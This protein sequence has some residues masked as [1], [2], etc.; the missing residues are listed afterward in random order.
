MVGSSC[1]ES[2][3]FLLNVQFCTDR[4]FVNGQ[5]WRY[6]KITMWGTVPASTRGIERRGELREQCLTPRRGRKGVSMAAPNQFPPREKVSSLPNLPAGRRHSRSEGGRCRQQKTAPLSQIPAQIKKTDLGIPGCA[7]NTT[8]RPPSVILL[9]NEGEPMSGVRLALNQHP[10]Q[11]ESLS[12]CREVTHKL[13]E[14][15]L[16]VVLFTDLHL[17]DGDWQ[18]VLQIAR[19]APAPVQVIVVSRIVDV[20]L[21]LDALDAGAFDFVVPPFC[22]ADLDYII[23]N[24]LQTC[25]KYRPALDSAIPATSDNFVVNH[26][27]RLFEKRKIS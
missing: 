19:E 3:L 8:C 11:V 14:L 21:Y 1:A 5:Y 23:V 25:P 6:L 9:S 17:P 7:L 22:T 16:P 18:E 26:T 2:R 24:A 13:A 12:S 20:G 27:N 10:L 15:H 4:T